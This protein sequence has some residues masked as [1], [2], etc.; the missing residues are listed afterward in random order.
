MSD[1]PPLHDVLAAL[2]ESTVAHAAWPRFTLDEA[3]W[4]KLVD[5]LGHRHW[6]LLAMWADGEAVHVALE[7]HSAG[8]FAIASHACVDERYASLAAVRPA[9]IRFE[10]AIRDLAG[11]DATGSPDVRP[12]L[13]HGQ[14]TEK[15]TARPATEYRFLPVEGDG[16]HQIPV[17][18][19]HA[20][21]IEPG[22]FRFHANG[23]T[24]VRLEARLGYT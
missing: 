1:R 6:P 18:P 24:I 14:W 10:R 9:A 8:A 20:G 3:G 2:G 13:D 12:W 23:E 4:T 16:P 7:D 17:G 11:L 21:I 15:S 22:H 19:V 5:T